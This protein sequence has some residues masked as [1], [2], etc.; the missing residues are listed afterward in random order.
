MIKHINVT[1]VSDQM[2]LWV[3]NQ[4]LPDSDNMVETAKLFKRCDDVLVNHPK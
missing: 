1:F 2:A 4:C 3:F